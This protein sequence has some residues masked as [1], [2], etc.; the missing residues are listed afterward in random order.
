[1]I[2]KSGMASVTPGG[3]VVDGQPVL[4]RACSAYLDKQADGRVRSTVTANSLSE[5]QRK[6]VT[7]ENEKI[8]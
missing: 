5:T 3:M 7:F 1:M 8:R 6:L 4:M 2:E